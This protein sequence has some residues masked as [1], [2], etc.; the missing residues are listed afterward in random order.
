[1][2]MYVSK[3]MSSNFH[4]MGPDPNPIVRKMEIMII[5][6]LLENPGGF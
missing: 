5:L 4:R 1:M 3:P 2:N 6:K